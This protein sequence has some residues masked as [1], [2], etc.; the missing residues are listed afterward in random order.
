MA[1][2]RLEYSKTG[3]ARWLSHLELIRTF[4]RALRRSGLPLVFSQGFNPHPRLSYGPSLGVGVAGLREYLDLDLAAATPLT[5]DLTSVGQQLPPGLEI[6]R[7]MELPPAAPGIGKAINCAWYR[8]TLPPEQTVGA[9][10]QA[11]DRLVGGADP[12]Y[13]KRPKDG[14]LF[15]V[16]SGLAA[17]RLTEAGGKSSETGTAER[18]VAPGA[19]QEHTPGLKKGD[20]LGLDLLV[21]L[22]DAAA[23]LR[24][25]VETLLPLAEA[26]GCYEPARVTRM[27]LLHQ[28]GGLVN[29]L[30]AQ[31]QLWEI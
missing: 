16:R 14:K 2:Y 30:G 21:D 4:I 31:K 9:W 28:N 8:L 20:C 25:I 6:S 15:D 17:C 29:P 19:W 13:Y 11:I 26:T 7:L 10:Q 1:E 5:E 18:E 23:P 24:G 22:G 3:R 27:A 12:L